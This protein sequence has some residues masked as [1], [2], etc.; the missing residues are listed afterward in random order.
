MSQKES[1]FIL[2]L[3]RSKVFLFIVILFSIA[4]VLKTGEKSCQK[5]QLVQEVDSLESEIKEL[6]GDNQKINDLISYFK[7]DAHL[8]NEARIKLNL[9]RPEEKVIIF[10]KD[11]NDF[12]RSGQISQKK[13]SLLADNDNAV[14]YFWDWLEYFFKKDLDE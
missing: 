5:H 4:L 2:R 8:E 6:E 12:S 7:K 14:N 1:K 13:N 11:E 9:K 10:Q 3:F